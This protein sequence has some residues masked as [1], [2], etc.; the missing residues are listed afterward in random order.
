MGWTRDLG[1]ALLLDIIRI[2]SPTHVIQI[3]STIDSKKNFAVD[4]T[5]NSVQKYEGFKFGP[6]DEIKRL[7]Y[8]LTVIESLLFKTNSTQAKTNRLL[9][10]LSYI[11][12]MR[13]IIFKPISAMTPFKYCLNY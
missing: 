11:S 6:S 12:Q 13:D 5:S 9:T 10:Q 2:S 4:L 7:D 3:D 1:L 8:K